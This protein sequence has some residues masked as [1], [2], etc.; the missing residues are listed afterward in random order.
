[1]RFT[2]PEHRVL[3]S[4]VR[5]PATHAMSLQTH[6]SPDLENLTT[7]SH[8][9]DQAH[10]EATGVGAAQNQTEAAI[11]SKIALLSFGTTG[12]IQHSPLAHA[13]Y[14]AVAS[15]VTFGSRG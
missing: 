10:A 2:G 9:M 1:M 6:A 12:C 11:R 15:Q 14:V 8:G 3:K 13:D 7:A 5:F 4:L